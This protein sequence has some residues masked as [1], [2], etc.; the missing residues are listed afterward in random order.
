MPGTEETVGVTRTVCLD[1]TDGAAP[2][3][4]VILLG[5]APSAGSLHLR[6][7]VLELREAEA[8]E[9]CAWCRSHITAVRVLTED[10]VR[11]AEMGEEIGRG[12][13]GDLARRIGRLAEEIGALGVLGRIV[14]RVKGLG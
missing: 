3:A 5:V 10:L 4:D 9:G 1:G 13:V 6:A 7:A 8:S 14:H 12:E 11:V 2:T